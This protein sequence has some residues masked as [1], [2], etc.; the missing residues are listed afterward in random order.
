[1]H[2]A[3]PDIAI[4]DGLKVTI[5]ELTCPYETNTKS[6][7]EYKEKRYEQLRYELLTPT[8]HFELI[9]LEITSLGFVTKDVKTM[10]S[11]LKTLNINAEYVIRKLQEVAV[12]C[13]YYIFTVDAIRNGHLLN[14]SRTIDC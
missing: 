6:A 3:R 1:M 14:L 11:F 2:R 5:I 4:K 9:L 7:R 12:R 10:K 13:S 8:S